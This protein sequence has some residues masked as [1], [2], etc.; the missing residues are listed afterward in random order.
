MRQHIDD[1]KP[2]LEK[3]IVEVQDSANKVNHL[4]VNHP[5]IQN[6]ASKVKQHI[7]DNKPILEK[8]IVEIQ[9]SAN[10]VKQNVVYNPEVQYFANNMKQYITEAQVS[11]NK[12]NQQIV[13]NPGVQIFAS[14]VKQHID[15]YQPELE[16]II[17]EVQD[18]TN[19]M[20][21]HFVNK[22]PE[23]KRM[24]IEPSP[25]KV[26]A[27]LAI[28]YFIGPQITYSALYSLGFRP[29]GILK[30]SV[31]AWAMSLHKGATPPGGIV[32]TSQSFAA[33]SLPFVGSFLSLTTLS[34]TAAAYC[35]ISAIEAIYILSQP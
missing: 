15:Y 18:S 2:L 3:S 13:S 22:Q 30:H 9:N 21:Q 17:T 14:K 23:L 10:K 12:V 32:S 27:S 26:A 19:R 6:F 35:S 16:K 29:E 28:G 34:G 4:I 5:E 31:A 11:A 20:R 1:N 8:I 25:K 24:F 33:T 7:D